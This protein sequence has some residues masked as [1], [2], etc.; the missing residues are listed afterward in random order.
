VAEELNITVS[1]VERLISRA[2]A[3]LRTELKEEWLLD[4]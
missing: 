1:A 4:R 3:K 2:L